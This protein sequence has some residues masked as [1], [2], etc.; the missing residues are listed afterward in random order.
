MTVLMWLKKQPPCTQISSK[1]VNPRDLAGNAEEE[2]EENDSN[3]KM[4]F[5]FFFCVPQPYHHLEWD[6]CICERFL[7]QPL[8]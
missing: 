1:M 5:F 8:R 2:E 3:Y 4:R 6:F 7:I